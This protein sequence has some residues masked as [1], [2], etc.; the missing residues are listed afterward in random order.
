MKCTEADMHDD[1]TPNYG[2]RITPRLDM[3]Y[4]SETKL[5]RGCGSDHGEAEHVQ[6]FLRKLRRT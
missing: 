5:H 2:L 1:R 6:Q 3:K 4:R